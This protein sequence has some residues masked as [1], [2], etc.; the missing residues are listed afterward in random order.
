MEV[1][2]IRGKTGESRGDRRRPPDRP[3][4]FDMLDQFV[5]CRRDMCANAPSLINIARIDRERVATAHVESTV[6]SLVNWRMS[7]KQQMLFHSIRVRRHLHSRFLVRRSRTDGGRAPAAPPFSGQLGGA[8][9]Q[10][11]LLL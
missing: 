6:T 8:I 5:D 9:E 2:L 3:C 11:M 7:K 1:G 10:P 4:G